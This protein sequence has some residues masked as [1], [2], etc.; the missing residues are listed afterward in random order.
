MRFS[1]LENMLMFKEETFAYHK[2]VF[3]HMMKKR[4]VLRVI[5]SEA[6]RGGEQREALF[7]FFTVGTS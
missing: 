2:R 1:T 6:L 7:R 5:L 3:Q 4:E